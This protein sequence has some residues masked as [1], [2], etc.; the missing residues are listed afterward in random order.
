M[1]RSGSATNTPDPDHKRIEVIVAKNSIRDSQRQKVYDAEHIAFCGG[2]DKEHP[3][4]DYK[5][6]A[7]CQEFVDRVTASDTWR[8]LGFSHLGMFER[9]P[10]TVR[11]GRGRG[12]GGANAFGNTIKLPKWT[13]MDYYILHEL[14]HIATSYIHDF[15][16]NEYD[17]DGG[18]WPGYEDPKTG[19]AVLTNNVASH[20]PEYAGIYLYL[21]REF[22]SVEDHDKL[23]AA[24]EDGKVKVSPIEAP[25]MVSDTPPPVA[26]VTDTGTHDRHCLQCG[27]VLLGIRSKFCSDECRWTYHNH[28][29]HD[30]TEANR[31][32][33]CEICGTE[34]TAG[35][36]D[37]KTCSPRC[38][39]RLRRRTQRL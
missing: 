28:L 18:G 33:V 20:G 15:E 29:R 26:P 9:Y 17:E 11:D 35:R 31:Q 1:K 36:A 38:R 24:F 4:A 23:A 13:R 5:T 3:P 37:A 19:I 22:L 34:F 10:I 32:K 8:A 7:E 6:V 16:Y 25:V 27:I 39:Q 12:R 30:L 21:V 14:A 2:I